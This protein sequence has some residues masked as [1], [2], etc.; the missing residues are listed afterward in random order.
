MFGFRAAAMLCGAPLKGFDD[1][2]RDISYE[3]LGHRRA[4]GRE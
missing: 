4:R 2:G 3:E 1:V